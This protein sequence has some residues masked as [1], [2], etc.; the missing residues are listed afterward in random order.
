MDLTA[1]AGRAPER[2]WPSV[3]SPDHSQ[4][5]A[6]G[7]DHTSPSWPSAD[8]GVGRTLSTWSSYS[9]GRRRGRVLSAGHGHASFSRRGIRGPWLPQSF[10]GGVLS[11]ELRTSGQVV[12]LLSSGGSSPSPCLCEHGRGQAGGSRAHVGSSP[13]GGSSFPPDTPHTLPPRQGH[14]G[15]MGTRSGRAHALCP[16]LGSRP[17][18]SSRFL[19]LARTH[20]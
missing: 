17:A 10:P 19:P 11:E 6:Q 16:P 8:R 3:P 20:L 2:R 1:H 14:R 4:P 5:P 9:R 12:P 15:H 13:R 18:P 7:S